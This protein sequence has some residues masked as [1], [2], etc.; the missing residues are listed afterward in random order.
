MSQEPPPPIPLTVLTGFLGAGKTTI[1][2]RLLQ[3]PA[4][5]DGLPQPLVLAPETRGVGRWLSPTLYGFYPE[6]GLHAAIEYDV[7]IRADITP[8]G[9]ARL[10]KPVSWRFAPEDPLL[11][12]TG[13]TVAASGAGRAPD[14]HDPDAVVAALHAVTDGE[15]AV[16]AAA[17]RAEIN[18][19]PAPAALVSDLT[20]LA[21]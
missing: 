4:L 14:R 19:L 5:A 13:E 9:K 1:L 18:A 10:E 12:A 6:S 16:A 3:D 15:A 21:R 11:V 7:T 20:K 17:V 2:N 8:D